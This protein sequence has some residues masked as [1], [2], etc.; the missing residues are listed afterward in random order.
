MIKKLKAWWDTSRWAVTLVLV[1]V[2][3]VIYLVLHKLLSFPLDWRKLP[4]G[5]VPTFLPP[6]PR[7]LVDAVD[8]AHEKS[9]T[10]RIEAK[11]KA[12]AEREK[13]EAIKKNSDGAA[14]RK[15]LAAFLKDL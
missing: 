6:V 2:L 7:V 11:V 8:S 5:Q 3:V 1:G 9:M 4:P 15:E 14:R 12:D 10:S 13:L